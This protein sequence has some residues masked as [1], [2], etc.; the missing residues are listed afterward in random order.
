MK[1]YPCVSQAV[2]CRHYQMR[3]EVTGK[4]GNCLAP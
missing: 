4:R 3:Y 2:V 1:A